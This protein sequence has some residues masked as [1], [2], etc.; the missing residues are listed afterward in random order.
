MI[1]NDISACGGVVNLASAAAASKTPIFHA[2]NSMRPTSPSDYPSLYIPESSW[3][4]TYSGHMWDLLLLLE[5]Y[6]KGYPVL[7]LDGQS[8]LQHLF[9]DELTTKLTITDTNEWPAFNTAQL[10]GKPN[11][12]WTLEFTKSANVATP[13]WRVDKCALVL[14]WG[15]GFSGWAN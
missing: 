15:F 1:V 5:S 13:N 14:E 4:V 12:T 8:D 11:S 9:I 10:T 6:P 2:I 7:E 3:R